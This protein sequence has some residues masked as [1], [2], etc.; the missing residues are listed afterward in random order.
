MKE[1]VLRF[2]TNDAGVDLVE[3]TLLAGLLALAG[4][5]GFGATGESISSIL[6]NL[7]KHL[8]VPQ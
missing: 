7:A 6:G 4:L 5:A 1:F 2:V 8:A 3:Y